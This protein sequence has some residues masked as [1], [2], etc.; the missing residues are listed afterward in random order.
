MN[1]LMDKIRAKVPSFYLACFLFEGKE[2][3]LGP[4]AYA[5]NT[6]VPGMP[7]FDESDLEDGV[8]C[9]N[10]ALD[11]Y[12]YVTGEEESTEDSF[13]ECSCDQVGAVVAEILNTNADL[14]AEALFGSQREAFCGANTLSNGVLYVCAVA[15]P[16][17]ATIESPD[18]SG[19]EF[20]LQEG[21]SGLDATF[22]TTA[23]FS[24]AV[25]V[26]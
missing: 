26:A 25:E 23:Q 2:N 9:Y 17:S 21:W 16:S 11:K 6:L 19:N 12:E 24:N 4:F 15:P 20:E 22:T 5:D 13:E 1:E 8:W 18:G 3:R 10:V 14:V 7:F